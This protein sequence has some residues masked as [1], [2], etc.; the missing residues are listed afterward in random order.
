MSFGN[1]RCHDYGLFNPVKV[2]LDQEGTA[3]GARFNVTRQK[4]ACQR[5]CVFPGVPRQG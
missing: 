5:R 1:L 3:I 2:T 4:A